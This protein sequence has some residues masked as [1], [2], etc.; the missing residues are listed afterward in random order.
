MLDLNSDA[1]WNL[2]AED[3]AAVAW[4]LDAFEAVKAE[5]DLIRSELAGVYREQHRRS[6]LLDRISDTVNQ[7]RREWEGQP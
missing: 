2:N 3:R 1:D 4:A 7:V 5:R 6:A